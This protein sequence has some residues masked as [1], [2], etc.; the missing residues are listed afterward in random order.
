MCLIHRFPLLKSN[1]IHVKWSQTK[2]L[3]A[4]LFRCQN[5]DFFLLLLKILGC[6]LAS[7]PRSQLYPV[8]P[9]TG[10]Y[11]WVA[12]LV[13]LV[14]T[15]LA[16]IKFLESAIPARCFLSETKQVLRQVLAC[17]S[18]VSVVPSLTPHRPMSLG[19]HSGQ[20]SIHTEPTCSL[21]VIHTIFWH[22][23]TKSDLAQG[24]TG[25]ILIT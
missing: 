7:L 6:T 15:T 3:T 22:W 19:G 5:S 10:C 8:F 14:H 4:N 11:H 16:P 23:S 18:L 21:S 13:G 9:L 12:I 24:F 1:Q 20:T 17:V 25:Y 2:S